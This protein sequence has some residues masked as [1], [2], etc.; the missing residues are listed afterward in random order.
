[1]LATRLTRRLLAAAVALGLALAP[2]ASLAQEPGPS[3]AA[4]A[5]ASPPVA[6]SVVLP[7]GLWDVAAYDAWAEGLVEPRPAVP[8]SIS[9]LADGRLEGDVGCG[10]LFGGY[11]LDGDGLSAFVTN[12]GLDPC[13]PQR[14]EDAVAFTVALEAVDSWRAA[15]DGLELLDDSGLVRV[16]L[17]PVTADSPVGDWVVLRIARANGKLRPG[18]Q[19]GSATLSLGADGSLTGG[20]GC[21]LFDGEF[22]SERDR[23]TIVP[24]DIT[25]LPCDGETRTLE[26]R[27]LA[28]IDRVTH[29]E[30][31]ETELRLTDGAGGILVELT[32][33]DEVLKPA[34]S[35]DPVALSSPDP[36]RPASPAPAG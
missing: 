29:W 2:A 17:A 16:V 20:T 15:G 14:I 32:E 5:S 28:A 8:Y 10:T 25:G 13:G 34:A 35:P 24:I 7:A 1:M 12:K 9:F 4:D 6:A 27:L 11:S 36:L 23:I 33:Q 31:H 18:P 19:D 22:S 3:P 26:R 21:R 30:R